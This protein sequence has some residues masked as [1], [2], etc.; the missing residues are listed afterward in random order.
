M[1]EPNTKGSI[2]VKSIYMDILDKGKTPGTE[3][4]QW[5]PEDGG[6]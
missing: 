1:E 6:G 4:N 2:L 5:S 3:T